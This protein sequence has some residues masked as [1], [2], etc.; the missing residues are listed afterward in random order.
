MR[1]S[2]AFLCTTLYAVR[3]ANN[4][5][6]FNMEGWSP[7]NQWALGDINCTHGLRE[8]NEHTQKQVYTIGV[9]APAGVEKAMNEYNLTFETYLTEVVGKRFDPPIEFQ[10]KATE[11]PLLSWIDLAEEVDFMYSDTGLYSC[12]GTEIGAQPLATT[13]ASLESRGRNYELDVY[14]GESLRTK[15]N[16]DCLVSLSFVF[17]SSKARYWRSQATR[18]STLSRI[19]R[20]R[21]LLARH[22]QSSRQDKA[23][24]G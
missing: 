17:Q 8:F 7:R 22:S 3:G 6:F 15:N 9:H 13:I 5:D 4:S 21:R 11:W 19:S 14:G 1:K 24:F 16:F 2:L 23:S 12:I 18:I 20:E 10:M